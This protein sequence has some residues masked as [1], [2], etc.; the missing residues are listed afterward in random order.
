MFFLPARHL[1]WFISVIQLPVVRRS[2]AGIAVGEA[3]CRSSCLLAVAVRVKLS[4]VLGCHGVAAFCLS[5][6][7]IR[8]SAVCLFSSC[9]SA[10]SQCGKL[11]R[12]I[13][14]IWY[15]RIS[16]L[17]PF[18]FGLM[19]TPILSPFSVWRFDSLRF[20]WWCNKSLICYISV[21]RSLPQASSSQLLKQSNTR[22]LHRPSTSSP[23]WQNSETGDAADAVVIQV[24]DALLFSRSQQISVVY[25]PGE[26]KVNNLV[27]WNKRPVNDGGLY[28][29]HLGKR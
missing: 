10:T 8:E 3:S 28:A 12:N 21:V 11:R 19:V 17:S 9:P 2:L 18:S 22:C 5:V 1:A 26:K 23:W 15:C 7:F 24:A 29:P 14:L 16:L 20:H 27:L 6:S 4:L 25:S 13:K